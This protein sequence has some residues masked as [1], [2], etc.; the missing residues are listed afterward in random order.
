[1][2]KDDVLIHRSV[3]TAIN[4]L[5]DSLSA[6]GKRVPGDVM[7]E[8]GRLERLLFNGHDPHFKGDEPPGL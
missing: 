4:G 2:T 8:A 3:V 5:A 6:E 1:M 7:W